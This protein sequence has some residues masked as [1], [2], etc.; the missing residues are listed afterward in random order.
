MEYASELID[1]IAQNKI[2]F[3]EV[4]VHITYDEYSL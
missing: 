1:K 3:A 4:P 2:P